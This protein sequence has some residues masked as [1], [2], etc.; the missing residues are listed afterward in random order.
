HNNHLIFVPKLKILSLRFSYQ[1][2]KMLLASCIG[3]KFTI[4]LEY[5]TI[6]SIFDANAL[7][8]PQINQQFYNF[9]NKYRQLSI[10]KSDAFFSGDFYLK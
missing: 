1:S 5:S 9:L 6:T 3:R 10:T 8:D 4:S 7:D 2:A